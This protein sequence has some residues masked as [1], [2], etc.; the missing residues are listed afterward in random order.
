[1]K[2]DITEFISKCL[3]RQQVK[4]EYQKP[5]GLLQQLPILEWK[6]EMI[7]I[8]FVFGLSR[9]SSGFDAIWVIVDRLTKS[10]YFLSIKKT[11]TTDRLDRLY[12]N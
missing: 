6:W 10:A 5:S 11:C 3:T 9:T 1:M 7:M 12:I 2:R 8:D 4:L